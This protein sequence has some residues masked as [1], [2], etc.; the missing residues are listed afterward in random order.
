MSEALTR[1]NDIGIRARERFG[2][3]SRNG[4]FGNQ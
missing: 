3:D 4:S 1:E 2:N